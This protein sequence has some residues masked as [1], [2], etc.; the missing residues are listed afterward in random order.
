MATTTSSSP[1]LAG[2]DQAIAAVEAEARALQQQYAQGQ[3]LGEAHRGAP[4]PPS[5]GYAP[6][7]APSAA[8]YEGAAAP[9]AYP[10][11]A[12]QPAQATD[13]QGRTLE[14]LTL[15]LSRLKQ[16][17]DWLQQDDRLLPIV[18]QYIGQRVHAMEKRTNAVNMRLAV[19]T[20]IAGAALGWLTSLAQTPSS[21]LHAVFR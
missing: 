5:A 18:D 7:P 17:K 1:I 16:M 8:P 12:P 15:F 3:A 13:A 20:T 11:A 21:L 14:D 10:A 9:G 2:L 4:L 19:I 6:P